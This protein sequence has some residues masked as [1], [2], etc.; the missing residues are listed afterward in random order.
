MSDATKVGQNKRRNYKRRIG[1]NVGPVQ[2]RTAINEEK[3]RT[4]V[5]F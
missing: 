3:R 1:T 2:C 4:L 5:E